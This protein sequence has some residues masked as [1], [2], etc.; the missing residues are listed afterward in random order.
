MLGF[1]TPN[2][3]PF[4]FPE[5]IFEL[6]SVAISAAEF[7]AVTSRRATHNPKVGGSNPP[8]AT[9]HSTESKDLPRSHPSVSF[10]L[11]HIRAQNFAQFLGQ[12]PVILADQMRV[13]HR[14][15]RRDVA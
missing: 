1:H 4:S 8:P 3:L 11:G 12:Q 6:P 14:R 5:V 10:Q 13:A 15:L 2:P 9:N 7:L